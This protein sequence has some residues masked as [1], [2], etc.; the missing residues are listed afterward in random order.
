MQQYRWDFKLLYAGFGTCF[1]T[2]SKAHLKSKLCG[3]ILKKGGAMV[4]RVVSTGHWATALMSRPE[5]RPYST[6][7]HTSFSQNLDSDSRRVLMGT[8]RTKGAGYAV[9][10]TS[11]LS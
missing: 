3:A 7:G 8:P 1:P 2:G 6:G 4:R 11:T 10:K 5:K 9:P